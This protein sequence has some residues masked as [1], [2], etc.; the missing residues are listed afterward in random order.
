MGVSE[1]E[2]RA[3]DA[4]EGLLAGRR[5][6]NAEGTLY[7]FGGEGVVYISGPIGPPARTAAY[8]LIK[9]GNCFYIILDKAPYKIRGL[10][11]FE[12]STM[13]KLLLTLFYRGGMI[14]DTYLEE[15]D[16]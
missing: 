14:R 5:F 6:V 10:M 3:L 11:H 16:L 7:E 9:D 8:E 15:V 1:E 13:F 4:Y 12:E 2:Q